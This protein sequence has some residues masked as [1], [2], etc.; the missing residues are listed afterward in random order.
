MLQYFSYGKVLGL[1]AATR[2]V[3]SKG[4]GAECGDN[5]STLLLLNT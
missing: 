3:L 5:F 4:V 2:V 1:L